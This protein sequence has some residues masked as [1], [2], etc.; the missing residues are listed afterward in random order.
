[1]HGQRS[2]LRW[3]S[4]GWAVQTE[5][6]LDSDA[7]LSQREGVGLS[8]DINPAPPTSAPQFQPHCLPR[9]GAKESPCRGGGR[10]EQRVGGAGWKSHHIVTFELEWVW[11][12]CDIPHVYSCREASAENHMTQRKTCLRR[13]SWGAFGFNCVAALNLQRPYLSQQSK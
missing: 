4:L 9:F 7:S 6:S 12:G 1:M 2:A 11:P 13:L 10:C 3:R 8:G 5:E